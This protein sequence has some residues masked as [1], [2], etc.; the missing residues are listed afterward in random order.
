MTNTQQLIALGLTY[1]ETQVIIALARKNPIATGYGHQIGKS[2]SGS[3]VNIVA[4]DLYKT[5]I[6]VKSREKPSHLLKQMERVEK[7][8]TRAYNLQVKQNKDIE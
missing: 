2:V 7:M 5:V 4:I 3:I 1:K 6:F 8:I